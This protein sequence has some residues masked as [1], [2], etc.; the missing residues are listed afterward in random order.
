MARGSTLGRAPIRAVC[1]PTFT[2]KELAAFPAKLRKKMRNKRSCKFRLTR[3]F[4]AATFVLKNS[5]GDYAIVHPSTKK[6]KTCQVSLF[7]KEGPWGDR[8]YKTCSAAIA[9]MNGSDWRLA[10]VK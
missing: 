6:S 7:D 4:K 10:E 3:P 8:E 9:S 2:Q 5:P 1:A